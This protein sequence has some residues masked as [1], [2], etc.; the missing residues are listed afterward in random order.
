ML[1]DGAY[2]TW[3]KMVA[4][5]IVPNVITQRALALAF[6]G[7]PQMA[8]ALVKE[9]QQLQAGSSAVLLFALGA[10]AALALALDLA[11]ALALAVIVTQDI[12]HGAAQRETAEWRECC[13]KPESRF[14]CAFLWLRSVSS[15][16]SPLWVHFIR[17]QQWA[18]E[19]LESHTL[20]AFGNTD[21]SNSLDRIVC[22]LLPILLIPSWLLAHYTVLPHW[23]ILPNSRPC[24]DETLLV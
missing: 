22:C 3:Q 14:T 5:K 11:L 16:S 24:L 2:A 12:Q 18:V 4:L 7:N 1:Q 23:P 9:A 17:Q 8:S 21:Q 6:G 20:V 10:I 13:Q 19:R 15:G